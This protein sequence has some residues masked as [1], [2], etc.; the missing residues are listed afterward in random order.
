MATVEPKPSGPSKFSKIGKG[1]LDIL[2]PERPAPATAPQAAPKDAAPEVQPIS[3]A[4]A[5]KLK[6]GVVDD[7]LKGRLWALIKEKNLEGFDFFEF[8]RILDGDKG[9]HTST[10][11]EKAFEVM[12]N[13]DEEN[14]TPKNTLISSASKYLGIL[15][16]EKANFD[17]GFEDIVEKSVGVKRQ[18][19]EAATK[20]VEDLDRQRQELEKKINDQQVVMAGLEDEIS[21]QDIELQRQRTN[22]LV[23]LDAVTADIQ[24]KVDNITQ[25]V[26]NDEAATATTTK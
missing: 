22:F 19:L 11:Y 1:L 2:M 5:V 17:T 15:A 26:P 7:E 3:Q 16:T 9:M 8:N 24:N 6:S 25:F 18:K 10:K 4:S 21:K 13:L 20:E 12:R 14:R 23:T